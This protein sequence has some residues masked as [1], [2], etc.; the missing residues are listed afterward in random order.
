MLWHDTMHVLLAPDR[1]DY[2]FQSPLGRAASA[3]GSVACVPDDAAQPWTAACATLGDVIADHMRNRLRVD[4][5]VS[6]RLAHY[7]VLPWRPGIVSRAE[8]RAYAMHGFAAVYGESA[9]SWSMRIDI[10]PPGRESLACA[11]NTG[12]IEALRTVAATNISRLVAVRPNF[13]TL[14]GQ[15]RAAMRGAHLW[16]GAV[17]ANHVC[18]GVLR[19][20]RWQA[21][22]NEAAPDG[23]QQALPGMIR[24]MQSSLDEASAGTVYM[25][26][27]IDA[28]TVPPVIEGLPVRVLASPSA[29]RTQAEAS[30][31]VDA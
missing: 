12:M 30:P 15:R 20:G 17:E 25:C 16:F 23:W 19:K 4:V 22:R 3:K 29:R 8:W 9:K 7:L 24:R 1:V 27:D 18:L 6:D 21:L 2:R 26:G 10:V 28:D 13:V 14:F 11:L 5:V 31:T